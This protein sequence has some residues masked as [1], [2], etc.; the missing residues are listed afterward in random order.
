MTLHSWYHLL[1]RGRDRKLDFDFEQVMD[2]F[3]RGDYS[4]DPSG[5]TSY[6]TSKGNMKLVIGQENNIEA[7]QPNLFHGTWPS[8]DMHLP[9]P[10][11]LPQEEDYTRCSA[12]FR[13]LYDGAMKCINYWKAKTGEKDQLLKKTEDQ[14]S[15]TEEELRRTKEELRRAQETMRR[16]Q[17]DVRNTQETLRRCE[18]DLHYAQDDI[19]FWKG[20]YEDERRDYNFD[21]SA[22]MSEGAALKTS[23]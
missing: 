23:E 10:P 22:D 12:S 1:G 11:P 8:Y 20:T 14:L 17:D 16:A 7:I 19:A 18:N 21:S 6:F 2:C 9:P 13:S 3:Y 4:P 5:S 15:T